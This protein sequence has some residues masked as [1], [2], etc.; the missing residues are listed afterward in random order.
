MK[1]LPEHSADRALAVSE[2]MAQNATL[3]GLLAD[4]RRS[5]QCMEV[6]RAVLDTGLAGLLKPGPYQD[7][8]WVMLADHGQAAAKVRH[9]LPRVTAALQQAGLGV[10]DV[11]VRVSRARPVAG[12]E[13]VPRHEPP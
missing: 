11:Q 4:W 7:G 1:P 13:A 9:C 2:A 10:R 6:A 3:G 5:A 12:R 8:L